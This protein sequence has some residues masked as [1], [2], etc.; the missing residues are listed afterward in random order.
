M[1]RLRV[2][3]NNAENKGLAK[4][5]RSLIEPEMESLM[6]KSPVVRGYLANQFGFSETGREYLETR[7]KPG[8]A[9]IGITML[10]PFIECGKELDWPYITK[11]ERDG[12]YSDL[13]D[14][15][16]AFNWKVTPLNNSLMRSS[17]CMLAILDGGADVDSGVASEIG[18][19]FGIRKGPIFALRSDFRLSENPAAPIN[20][21][22]MGYIALSK[23]ELVHGPGSLDRWFAKIRAWYD[24][25]KIK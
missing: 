17:D 9:A 24:S 21:Q 5:R 1:N 23:G 25:L 15:W 12:R 22:V 11:L 7:I 16:E 4:R 8:I 18:F 10:D 20:A 3:V 6:A 19:Y 13:K 14:Y 2:F